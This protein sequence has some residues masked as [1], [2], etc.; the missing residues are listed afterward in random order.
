MR[1]VSRA[2]LLAAGLV[3]AS[4][5]VSLADTPFP[6]INYEYHDPNDLKAYTPPGPNV[7]V[8][9]TGDHLV[10]PGEVLDQAR[11]NDPNEVKWP[12]F[13]KSVWEKMKDKYQIVPR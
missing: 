13:D 8:D 7:A 1:L 11:L 3:L 10:Y 4:P 5:V 6:N 9:D 12:T 2:L